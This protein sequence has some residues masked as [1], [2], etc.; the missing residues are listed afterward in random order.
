MNNAVS[1]TDWSENTPHGIFSSNE[2]L[3]LDP[4]SISFLEGSV[5]L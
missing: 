2:K 3:L 1:H 4:F 5:N